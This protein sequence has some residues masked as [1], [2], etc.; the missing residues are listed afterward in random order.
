MTPQRAELSRDGEDSQ[1]VDDGDEVSAWI[2]QEE[3][4]RT[5]RGQSVQDDKDDSTLFSFV[6]KV[7]MKRKG[8]LEQIEEEPVDETFVVPDSSQD[9]TIEPPKGE[10]K[11]TRSRACKKL[12]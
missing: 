2:A 3:S 7:K 1:E 8:D 12:H 9:D 4:V 11:A 6:N 5:D 10:K